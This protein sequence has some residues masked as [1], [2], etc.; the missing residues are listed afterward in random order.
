M[1]ET[2][3]HVGTLKPVKKLHD[4]ETVNE[5]AKRLL[6]GKGIN[7]NPNENVMEQLR[8]NDY[9]KY[10]EYN[11]VLYEADNKELNGD[12]ICEATMQDDGTIKY[13]LQFYNGGTCFSEMMDDALKSLDK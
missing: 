7:V 6:E 3:S 11:G 9:D 12:D 2:E 13:A 4:S 5:I 1:S 8:E 10:F